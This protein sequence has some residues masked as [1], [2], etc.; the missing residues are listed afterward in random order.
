MIG[1]VATLFGIQKSIEEPLKS[2]ATAIEKPPLLQDMLPWPPLYR[3][4]NQVI[5]PDQV[6]DRLFL[7]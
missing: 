7:S 3:N 1:N 4:S 5:F 6:L 2:A